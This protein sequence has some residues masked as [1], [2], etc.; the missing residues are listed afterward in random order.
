M[1]LHY[2]GCDDAAM[3]VKRSDYLKTVEGQVSL[4]RK[5][6]MNR[7][8]FMLDGQEPRS[9]NAISEAEK[10]AFQSAILTKMTER[11][12]RHFKAPVALE[13]DFFPT[14]N[15]PPALHTMPKNYLD[16]LEGPVAGVVPKRK[17]LVFENDRQVS[18]LAAKYHI[19][20]DESRPSIWLKA[21][22]YRDFVADIA[23]LDKI[24]D[25]E[26]EPASNG[27]LYQK[28]SVSWDDLT[29]DDDVMHNDDAVDQ[30]REH[31]RN[32]QFWVARFGEDV[33]EAWR[34]MHIRD[35]QNHLLKTLALTPSKLI[36][37]L[38]PLFSDLPPEFDSIHDITRSNLISE[39]LTIDL[40]HSNLKQGESSLYKAFVK[41]T[42]AS[43][44]EKHSRLFPLIAKV[45]ITILFQP[46]AS[47]SIDLDNLARRIV[48][49]VNE[50][51]KPHSSLLMTVNTDRC[52]DPK[53]MDWYQE[54]QSALK[55]M[56]KHSITHYQVVHLPRLTDDSEHGFVRL[57]L[58]PGEHVETLWSKV[59]N[60]ADKWQEKVTWP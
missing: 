57:L 45:G 9:K 7:L 5:R 41:K 38:S 15:D 49:F 47:S 40:K 2:S 1:R 36:Y 55:R 14:E 28:S 54:K 13:F 39:P 11:K 34:E 59:E 4:R 29:E 6:Q 25:N 43:F 46:P 8:H 26:L 35:V 23:L 50:E 12:R 16:L 10:A 42:I 17:R 52:G 51:L 37:L 27:L 21:A 32:K 3:P 31:E 20:L 48:P 44:R 22:P 24:Q 60:L 33:Y 56:P 30:L 53:L 19:R 18:Y 58:E